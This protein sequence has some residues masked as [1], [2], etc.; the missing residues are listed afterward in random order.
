MDE[1]DGSIDFFN[2]T[3]SGEETSE[4][5]PDLQIRLKHSIV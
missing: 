3:T 2:K 1:N 5:S 4:I